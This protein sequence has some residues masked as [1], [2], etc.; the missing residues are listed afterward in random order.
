[1]DSKSFTAVDTYCNIIIT[2]PTSPVAWILLLLI[3][4]SVLIIKFLLATKFLLST[5]SLL[6]TKPKPSFYISTYFVWSYK[7]I[8]YASVL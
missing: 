3:T 8:T 7:A 1:M 5:K 2:G 4:K 6:L